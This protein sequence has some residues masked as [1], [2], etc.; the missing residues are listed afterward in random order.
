METLGANLSVNETKAAA[1]PYL[2]QYIVLAYAV[3]LM[4]WDMMAES[5]MKST[6]E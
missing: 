6:G 5:V 4:L 3:M 1:A 2:Q